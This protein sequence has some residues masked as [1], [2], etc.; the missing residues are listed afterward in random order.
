ME[1]RLKN[2]RRLFVLR[3]DTPE[4]IEVLIDAT[5]KGWETFQA[6]AD[7]MLDR[8]EVKCLGYLGGTDRKPKVLNETGRAIGEVLRG[9]IFSTAKG[10]EAKGKPV[11]RPSFAC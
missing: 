5:A 11:P 1:F 7:A 8:G 3:A 9:D 2:G 4:R 6:L 10:F